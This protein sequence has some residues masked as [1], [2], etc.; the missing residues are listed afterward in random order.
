MRTSIPTIF[1]ALASLSVLLP[2]AFA[3]YYMNTGKNGHIAKTEDRMTDSQ[4]HMQTNKQADKQADK[5]KDFTPQA[6]SPWNTA[7]TG[8][9]L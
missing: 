3:L 1:K 2:K 9:A 5:Y 7:F 8:Q 6:H 4:A